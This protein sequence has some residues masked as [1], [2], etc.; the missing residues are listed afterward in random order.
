MFHVYPLNQETMKKVGIY[1][2]ISGDK[3]EGKDTSIESQEERGIVFAKSLNLPYQLYYD[4]GKSGTTEKRDD[5]PRFIKDIKN[6]VIT[7]I[8]AINQSRIERSPEVWQL[9]QSTVVGAKARWYPEGREFDL[10]STMNRFIASVISLVNQLHADLTS[11][12]VKIA[13]ANNAKKGKGH[14]TKAYGIMYDEHG[15]MQHQ[16][17]EIE[18][19]KKIFKWSLEGKGAYTIANILNERNIPTRYNILDSQQA[20]REGK[21]Q[22]KRNKKWWGSTVT[23]IL[24]NRLYMGIHDFGDTESE[25]P[26]LA[27]LTPEEFQDVQDNFAKNRRKVGKRAIRKYLMHSLLYCSDCGYKYF[28]KR[29]PAQRINTYKC[30]GAVSPVNVCKCSKGFNIY[31]FETFILKHLFYTKDLQNHLNSIEKNDDDTLELLELE[32]QQLERKVKSH[33]K[34]VTRSFNLLFESDDDDLA[35]D[36]RIEEKY[37]SDKKKLAQFKNKLSDVKEKILTYENGSVLNTINR[38]ID[39]FDINA[40]FES[41]REAVNNIIGRIDVE[42][43]PLTKN[44][45]FIFKIKYK[46]F[47]ERIEYVATQ[48]LDRFACVKYYRDV[49]PEI[50]GE[51]HAKFGKM[52][53]SYPYLLNL[54]LTHSQFNEYFDKFFNSHMMPVRVKKE[55]LIKFE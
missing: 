27:I 1:C 53:G 23:G 49:D 54:N 16:P 26:H 6:G 29:T 12:S 51:G 10:N 8:Y 32:K 52:E 24:N 3:D 39:G 17:E 22:N 47:D 44:G 45:R 50:Y 38:T 41:I 40:D 30:S 43:I 5:F 7:D 34:M 36:K 2:R 37:K 4:I 48:Q 19:V 25:H 33:E 42:Y 28:G 14:G 20:S 55:E 11:D 46:G 13:F 21:N 31:R 35:G 15:Y 9:F 18:V